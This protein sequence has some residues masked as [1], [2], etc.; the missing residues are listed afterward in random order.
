VVPLSAA[1]AAASVATPARLL[2]HS[3]YL[4]ITTHINSI[5]VSLSALSLFSSQRLFVL[6]DVVAALSIE[7]LPFALDAF[8]EKE[9][10]KSHPHRVSTPSPPLIRQFQMTV[11]ENLRV[12]LQGSKFC[13]SARPPSPPPPPSPYVSFRRRLL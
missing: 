13:A 5:A 9:N 1:L 12:L 11:A 2:Y 4:T 7:A 3:E 8:D 6:A 10:E